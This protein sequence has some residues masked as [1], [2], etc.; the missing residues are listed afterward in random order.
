MN[1]GSALLH[2][3]K[4]LACHALQV[5]HRGP[6]GGADCCPGGAVEECDEPGSRGSVGLSACR[7]RVA[8]PCASVVHCKTKPTYYIL[9]R[10]RGLNAQCSTCCT[11]G[12]AVV[13]CQA[14][15]EHPGLDG[16][17]AQLTLLPSCSCLTGTAQGLW[18]VALTFPA[19][20]QRSPV[21]RR[22]RGDG[23]RQA[24]LGVV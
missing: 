20:P 3:S 9:G 7:Q 19:G 22:E 18:P 2:S 14:V 1:A 15:R 17:R 11:A 6:A 12:N 10:G 13:G 5:A 23:R 4:G 16:N 21:G 24:A 8:K